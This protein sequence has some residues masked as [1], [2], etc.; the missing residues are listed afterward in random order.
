M[1]VERFSSIL[2]GY[3][4]PLCVLA[5]YVLSNFLLQSFFGVFTVDY[6]I[7]LASIII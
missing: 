1:L 2:L 6:I 7:I 4:H 5:P 3:V